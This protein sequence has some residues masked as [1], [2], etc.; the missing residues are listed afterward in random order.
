M[1]LFPLGPSARKIYSRNFLVFVI[2]ILSNL[3]VI[4]TCAIFDLEDYTQLILIPIYIGAFFAFIGMMGFG[5]MGR[6]LKVAIKHDEQDEVERL[7][8]KQPWD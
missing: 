6:G 1:N 7:K 4:K 5:P 3:V 8:P 2:C